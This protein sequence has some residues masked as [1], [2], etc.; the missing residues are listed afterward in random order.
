[1]WKDIYQ[2]RG[3]FCWVVDKKVFKSF[4]VSEAKC[5]LQNGGWNHN[6]TPKRKKLN[7]VVSVVKIGLKCLGSLG[8]LCFTTPL[9]HVLITMLWYALYIQGLVNIRCVANPDFWIVSKW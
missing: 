6:F 8:L 2:T 5:A 3:N 9:Y 4:Y 7:N 1:M